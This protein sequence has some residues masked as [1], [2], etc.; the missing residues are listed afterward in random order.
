MKRHDKK[1]WE[2]NEWTKE[3]KCSRFG[4]R[5]SETDVAARETRP[6]FVQRRM[7]A[8]QSTPEKDVFVDA[9]AFCLRF[10]YEAWIYKHDS[11]PNPNRASK[12][13]KQKCSKFYF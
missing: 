8:T 7:R 12:V 10:C 1:L 5:L 13:L 6:I 4:V 11:I 2:W 3:G 9:W